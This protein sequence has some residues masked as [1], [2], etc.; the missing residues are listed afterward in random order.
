M[1]SAAVPVGAADEVVGLPEVEAGTLE[2]AAFKCTL[3]GICCYEFLVASFTGSS[4]FSGFCAVD[5]AV[6]AAPPEQLS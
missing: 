3:E 6:T 1:Y 2:L 5:P 4:G